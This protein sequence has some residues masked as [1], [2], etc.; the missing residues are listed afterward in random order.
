MFVG[1]RSEIERDH[2]VFGDRHAFERPRN[3]ETARNATARAQVRCQLRDIL[4]TEHHGAGLGT[5]RAGNTVDQ[6]RLSRAVRTDQAEA[7]SRT[8]VDTDIVERGEAT[9]TFGKR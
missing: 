8:N 1:D 7:L 6:R 2:E 5:E 3:L 9:E 4:V